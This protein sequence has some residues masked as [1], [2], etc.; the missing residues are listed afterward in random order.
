MNSRSAVD[1]T[2]ARPAARPLHA[3]LAALT[4]AA[5]IARAQSVTFHVDQNAPPY[6]DGSSWDR[7]FNDLAVALN[8]LS[9]SSYGWNQRA[10]VELRIAQGIYHP[11]SDWS[12][13]YEGFELRRATGASGFTLSML[14]GFAGLA[15]LHPDL[16]DPT[17]FVTVLS[18]DMNGDDG[19]GFT[20]RSDNAERVLSCGGAD[21]LTIDGLVIEGAEA[22]SNSLSGGGGVMLCQYGGARSTGVFIRNTIFRNN[23]AWYFPALFSGECW[24]GAARTLVEDCLFSNNSC[25][26]AGGAIRA[27]GEVT[28]NRCRFFGNSSAYQG[29][30]VFIDS[31]RAVVQDSLFAANSAPLGGALA[32]TDRPVITMRSCTLAGNAA[33]RGSA[34]AAVDLWIQDSIIEASP[35]ATTDSVIH[36][37]PWTDHLSFLQIT[38]TILRGGTEG[39]TGAKEMLQDEGAVYDQDPGFTDPSGPD[40][41]FGA[42][43]DNDFSLRPGSPGI[44]AG[45]DITPTRGATDL[46]G[47]ARYF[48]GDG[49]GRPTIDM[50]AYERSVAPCPADLDGSGFVDT[51][52]FDAFIRAFEAG[53]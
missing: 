44:D 49:D 9:F 22:G 25:A 24:Q 42:W 27:G 34:I 17:R 5:S 52:D 31:G 2:P 21:S 50:G 46:A 30:A 7:A 29:G 12:G 15:G 14:G 10:Q 51:D 1:T 13:R 32:S 20:N 8:E 53:C 18:A 11:R 23:R 26:D 35:L 39:I 19:P 48:D 41:D 3:A 36:I 6:G 16:R 43:Q 37:L 38:S 4:L 47:R 33:P 45:R 28:I 40:Q